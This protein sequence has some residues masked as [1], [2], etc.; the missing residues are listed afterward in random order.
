MSASDQSTF[1][2]GE[3]AALTPRVPGLVKVLG[4][5]KRVTQTQ[6]FIAVVD[7]VVA[8]NLS[9]GLPTLAHERQAFPYKASPALPSAIPLTAQES[10]WL[11]RMATAPGARLSLLVDQPPK[12]TLRRLVRKG[13]AEDIMGTFWELTDLG[14]KR[15][16]TIY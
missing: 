12:R 16:T 11:V 5:V 2:V 6:C 1:V 14:R 13:L 3:V 4:L 9:D 15:C 7:D 8:F 10:S